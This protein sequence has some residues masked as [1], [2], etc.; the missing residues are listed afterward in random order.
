VEC[1]ERLHLMFDILEFVLIEGQQRLITLTTIVEEKRPRHIGESL[2][3]ARWSGQDPGR[4]NRLYALDGLL[5]EVA[6]AIG[7]ATRAKGPFLFIIAQGAYT[8][9]RAPG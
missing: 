5:I 6:I 8:H 2:R 9:S 7:E 4:F 3:S 1:G